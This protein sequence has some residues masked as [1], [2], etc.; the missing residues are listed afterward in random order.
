M[1]LFP[2]LPLIAGGFGAGLANYLSDTLPRTRR[3]TRPPCPRCGT[4]LPWGVYLAGRR[5]PTCGLTRGP[6]PWLVFAAMLAFSVYTWLQPHRMGYWPSLLLLTYFAVVVVIDLEHR[7]ILHVVSIAGAVLAA[8]IGIFLHGVAST[9]LG[10]AVGFAIMY[11]LYQLGALF[12]RLRARR[13]REAGLQ[14]DGEDALGWGD[15]MLAIVLGL[16][17]GWPLVW[18]GL[19]LGVLIGGLVGLAL[20]LVSIFRGRYGRQALM[21]F[22]PYGPAFVASAFCILFVPNWISALLPK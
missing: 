22:M 11:L 4:Q 18:F 2:I 1:W 12:S 8:A 3:L 16:L 13:M 21:L 10:G 17:L 19:L 15:V 20:V 14:A 6:R 5:C 7:L 9:L